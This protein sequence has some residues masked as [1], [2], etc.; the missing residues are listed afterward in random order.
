MLGEVACLSTRLQQPTA[1]KRVWGVIKKGPPVGGRA[2]VQGYQGYG[3][4]QSRV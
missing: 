2:V 3:V 4:T 1:Q